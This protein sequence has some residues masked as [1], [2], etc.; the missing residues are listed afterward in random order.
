MGNVIFK[1]WN[2][3]SKTPTRRVD[4]REQKYTIYLVYNVSHTQ[5]L[6]YSTGMKVEER[7]WNKRTMRVRD[8]LEAIGKDAINDRLNQ[9]E[10][11]TLS[12]VIG[13]STKGRTLTVQGLRNFLDEYTGKTKKHDITTLHKFVDDFIDKA[14]QR[15][16]PN[17][18]K[19]ISYKVKREYIRTYELLKRYEHDRRQGVELDFPDITLAFYD[20]FMAYLQNTEFEF[21]GK[22]QKYHI[23]TIKHKIIT[24]KTFLNAATH[25]NINKNMQYKSTR[26]K[27]IDEE[28][29]TIYLNADELEALQQADL[30]EGT[31]SKVRD[32]FILGSW[33]GLRFSDLMRLTDDDIHDGKIYLEQKKTMGKVVIP[34]FPVFAEIW[35]RYGR[36]LPM[37][38]SN[39]KYNVY[40]KEAC[41]LAGINTP[42]QKHM[43]IGG[44]RITKDYLKYE[45][46]GSHT[47]RRSFV[48][49][50]Y[51]MGIPDIQIMKLT[52]H[53]S[54]AFLGY[55][56]ES[57]EET[58][59]AVKHL[60]IDKTKT[61]KTNQA[62][63]HD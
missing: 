16:N 40:I 51:K 14:D 61:N 20:D 34:I 11:A 55:L 37:Q 3:Q 53:K 25:L 15:V 30:G 46:V 48:T 22:K 47:A 36:Q 33:T 2:R 62:D 23:K 63:K 49:N 9:L 41:K 24:L 35:E 42:V 8:R 10:N 21:N 6:K 31:L 44:E 4:G 32:L 12:Y 39:Q 27:A 28:A 54:T 29:D 52:G 38:I 58:A 18:G 17:T 13:E 43:T 7:W 56:R 50:L 60:V 19:T 26:F 45:L 5:R 57:R 1:L 59:E